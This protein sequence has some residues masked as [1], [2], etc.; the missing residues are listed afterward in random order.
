MQ[1]FVVTHKEV[2]LNLPDCYKMLMVGACKKDKISKD[3]L[4]D[5]TGEN[6][7]DRNDAYSELTGLYWIWKNVHCKYVGLVHYRRFFVELPP[8]IEIH[9][10]YVVQ[11]RERK[12][13]RV[14]EEND[15]KKIFQDSEMVVK[16]SRSQKQTN[17]ELF[18]KEFGEYFWFEFEKFFYVEYPEWR[19]GFKRHSV[20]HRHLNCNMFVGK[21]QIIDCYCAWLFPV[22]RHFDEYHKKSA[23]EYFHS[24]EIGYIS[25]YL[26]QIWLDENKVNYT[27]V[28]AVTTIDQ[29]NTEEVMTI[30]E[31]IK[32]CVK[33]ITDYG[34]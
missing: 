25:E 3:Y 28:D 10:R 21:K 23:G 22:L 7:S 8:Y 26:F 27:V 5:D 24:R 29:K 1:V 13:F 16:V 18:R 11:G 15:Y 30:K 12:C 33:R 6:I 31:F 20:R 9:G 17:M 19:E 34:R 4:C 14:L 2:R 32:Y